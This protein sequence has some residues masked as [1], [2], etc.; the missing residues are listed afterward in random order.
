MN[1]QDTPVRETGALEELRGWS[2]GFN[3]QWDPMNS[4]DRSKP[5]LYWWLRF[6]TEES[7]GYVFE[8][9]ENVGSVEVYW[10][11]FDHYDGNFRVPESWKLYYEKDNK[12]FQV[13]PTTEYTVHKDCYNML[14]FKPVTTRALKLTAKLQE[15]ESGGII[16]WKVNEPNLEKLI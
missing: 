3:D 12:W 7:V 13:E 1:Y 10:L 16:E 14:E 4:A 2:F 9:S 5:Y 11:D 15:G 6:G 8:K